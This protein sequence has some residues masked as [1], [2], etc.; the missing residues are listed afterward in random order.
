MNH[1]ETRRIKQ[2][3]IFVMALWLALG[4]TVSAAKQ[5][6]T[7]WHI[8]DREREAL[9]NQIAEDFMAENPDI[10]VK[11]SMMGNPGIRDKAMVA[12]AGGGG[13]DVLMCDNNVGSGFYYQLAIQGGLYPLD[14]LI[15]RDRVRPD[16][17]YPS[18]WES[19]KVDGQVY[20]LAAVISGPDMLFYNI[21][22]FEESGLDAN[23]PPVTWQDLLNA[24][25]K[26]SRWDDTGALT[27]L[28]YNV[29]SW[30][31]QYVYEGGGSYFDAA[32]KR[33]TIDSPAA[34]N[35]FRFFLDMEDQLFPGGQVAAFMQAGSDYI[36]NFFSERIVMQPA[37]VFFFSMRDANNPDMRMGAAARP[38]GPGGQP[39]SFGGASWVYAIPAD[40]KA[41]EAA[42][43]FVQY[44]GLG[45][46]MRDF[47]LV[48]SRPT[49]LRTMNSTREFMRVIPEPEL[50]GNLNMLGIALPR[51]PAIDEIIQITS[52]AWSQA[53]QRA[54]APEV[55]LSEAAVQAQAKLDEWNARLSATKK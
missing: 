7:V 15:S 25:R 20:G 52:R 29:R 32:G 36:Q 45:R 34:V 41:V 23:N 31:A 49:P 14:A 47:M 46:G 37:G 48:Q 27:R 30:F 35:A 24:T 9:F 18:V 10:E 38:Y 39:T 16:D 11:M 6:I 26:T 40:T 54:K 19:T 13:P 50:V 42:W 4:A 3:A 51:H 53:F 1:I 43:K 8:W 5:T 12:I 22:A 17:W 28:G 21:D 55:A 2:T 44:V 33:V